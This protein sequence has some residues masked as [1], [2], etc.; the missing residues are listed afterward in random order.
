M[1][2]WVTWKDSGRSDIKEIISQDPGLCHTPA[3]P[4]PTPERKLIKYLFLCDKMFILMQNSFIVPAKQ[5]GH[6]AK[7]LLFLLDPDFVFF[8]L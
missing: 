1:T 2:I 8:F 3:H 5:H 4:Y 6:H 7:P